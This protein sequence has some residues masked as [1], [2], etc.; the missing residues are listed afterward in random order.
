MHRHSSAL[1]HVQDRL[2]HVTV[3]SLIVTDVDDVRPV[4]Q[5]DFD[6]D[7]RQQSCCFQRWA[8][9]LKNANYTSN[10][11]GVLIKSYAD[12]QNATWISFEGE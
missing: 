1:K 7:L 3:H 10:G 8:A 4:D 2:L 12:N 6:S 11:R 9:A 5:T